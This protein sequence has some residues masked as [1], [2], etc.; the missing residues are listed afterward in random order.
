MKKLVD[1]KYSFVV[2]VVDGQ[3]NS[4][5]DI[6]CRSG[7]EAG[8]AYACEYGCPGGLCSKTMLKL[9]PLM[10]AVRAGGD[11]RNL[12]PNA[13]KHR[14]EFICPDGVVWFRLEAISRTSLHE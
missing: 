2:T 3:R 9:F 4:E 10:E 14:C 11:L 13:E 8:D 12:L 7:H 1:E 5:G 6:D